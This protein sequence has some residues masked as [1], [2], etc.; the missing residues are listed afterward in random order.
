MVGKILSPARSPQPAT[1]KTSNQI[2][3]IRVK[4]GPNIIEGIHIPI[5]AEVM[6]I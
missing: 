6:G 5:I 1:G 2:P 4:R 3:K